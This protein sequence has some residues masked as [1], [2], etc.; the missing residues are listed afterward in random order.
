MTK[1]QPQKKPI[2]LVALG[3]NALILKGQTGTVEEQ[4]DNLK[5][6]ISQ[7]AW[8]SRDYRIIITHGNGPASGQPPP[9]TGV[10]RHGAQAAA[11]RFSWPRPRDRSGT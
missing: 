2:L 3:G 9:S 4:F 11:W 7:I 8:L 10:L 1:E 6:P 5:I